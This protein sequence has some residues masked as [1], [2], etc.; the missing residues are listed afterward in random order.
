MIFPKKRLHFMAALS[1]TAALLI[2]QE[3]AFAGTASQAEKQR[4]AEQAG[5]AEGAGKPISDAD[6]CKIAQATVKACVERAGSS[7][8]ALTRCRNM[9][10]DLGR[11]CRR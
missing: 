4:A 8:P 3:P 6:A 10:N 9:A 1:V 2:P 11:S 5:T 7:I